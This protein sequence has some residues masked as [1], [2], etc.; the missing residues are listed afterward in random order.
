MKPKTHVLKRVRF[1]FEALCEPDV[2]AESLELQEVLSECR[3]GYMSGRGLGCTVKLLTISQALKACEEHATDPEFFQLPEYEIG[4]KVWWTDPDKGV[5]SGWYT[6][7]EW[8]GEFYK[9]TNKAG[10]E[11]EAYGRE[12]SL[13]EPKT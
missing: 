1:T 2:N 8:T 10:G 4:T 3:A 12:L 6:I 13:K 7:R 9:M 5:S 11:C